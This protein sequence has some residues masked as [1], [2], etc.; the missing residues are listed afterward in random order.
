M[1]QSAT[2]TELKKPIIARYVPK[3]FMRSSGDLPNRFCWREHVEPINWRL[4]SS[5]NINKIIEE[6]DTASL[7]PLSLHLTFC[8]LPQSETSLSHGRAQFQDEGRANLW[9]I[10]RILQLSLEYIFYLRSQDAIH[11]DQMM[12]QIQEQEQ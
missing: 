10:I 11:L 8:K 1:D 6:S 3:M 5:I 4:I 2:H 12:C 7:E 9:I